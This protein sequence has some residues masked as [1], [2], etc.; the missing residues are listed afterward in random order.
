M[1]N[2]KVTT[3]ASTKAGTAADELARSTLTTFGFFGLS[4]GVW[5]FLCFIAGLLAGGLVIGFFKAVTGG[6]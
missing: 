5:G 4:F 3:K 2:T 6:G 1:E